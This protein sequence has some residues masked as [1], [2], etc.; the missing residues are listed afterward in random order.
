MSK[1]VG[2][3]EI[4]SKYKPS[5]DQ[6]QAIAELVAGLGKGERIQT[7]LGATGTGKTFSVANVIE[8]VQRPTLVIAHNKTLAAQLCSEFREFF[9][10]NAVEYFVSYYDYYQPEAYIPQTDTFIE[11]DSSINE[12]VNRLRHSATQAVLE[13]RDVIIVASVS[14]IY[15]LGSP[16]AYKG[17]RVWFHTGQVYDRDESIKR[18]VNMQFTRNDVALTLGTFRVKGDVLELQPRDEEIIYR[19]EWDFDEVS[20]ISLVD[21]LTGEVLETRDEII[22]FPASH[23]VTDPEV[24][25]NSLAAIEDEMRQQVKR[26]TKEGKL[27]EA[28]RIE[29]RT[30]FDLEMIREV[31]FCSGIE[32]YSR[33]M[34]G[35]EPGT[36]PNTLLDYFPDDFLIVVDESHQTIP[37]LHAMYAGD[38]RR[39]DTLIEFGFRLPSARDNRPLRW[40]EFEERIKQVVF[41]SATPGP[42]ERAQSTVIAEQVIRPTGLI[43]PEIVIRPTKGQVDD[44]IGEIK[45]R[46]EKGERVLV[47]TLTKKMSED[48]TE[49]LVEIGTKVQYLHSDIQTLERTEILRD[50]R[51]GVYDVLV[52]INLLREGLDLPEVSLVAILD[53][54]KEG[55]LRSETSLVQTIGRAARNLGGQVIMYADRITGSMQRAIDETNRRR[56][57]QIAYNTANGITPTT[58]IKAVREVLESRKVAEAKQHYK[59]APNSKAAETLPLDQLLLAVTDM[60]KEMKQAAKALDFEHAAQIRDEIGRLKKLLPA[61]GGRR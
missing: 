19:I 9:P 39:K 17:A 6:P 2:K 40:E 14:C 28:Q 4:V 35:R 45:N 21:P 53:A 54:D 1:G 26:F 55:F 57:K 36:A 27:I 50:L 30:R 3:F 44:L 10:H 25:E 16:D 22:I 38:K 5:G 11:K 60:E 46:T 29:Q 18:L 31:G 51:L 37:Q 56:E 42:F 13:R 61:T 15:G 24:L 43:D 7:L 12:E 49:Y 47:T 58:V 41:I 23:F 48:L 52:G 34:D 33:W 20:R 8:Q 59:I 32:N